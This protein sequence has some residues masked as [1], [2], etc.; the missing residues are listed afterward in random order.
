MEPEDKT[1]PSPP[2]AQEGSEGM[3]RPAE[4]ASQFLSFLPEPVTSIALSILFGP[5]GAFSDDQ[6]ESHIKTLRNCLKD[7][8]PSQ[9]L[10]RFFLSEIVHL[11][12]TS[13]LTQKVVDPVIVGL[14]LLCAG[15]AWS[16]EQVQ[17]ARILA[18]EMSFSWARRMAESQQE[19]TKVALAIEATMGV[20][21][22]VALAATGAASLV[23][24]HFA[25]LGGDALM[26]G[27]LDDEELAQ[28]LHFQSELVYS[29]VNQICVCHA[30]AAQ[31]TLAEDASSPDSILRSLEEM[32]R[33]RR[34]QLDRLLAALVNHPKGTIAFHQ[35][36][37]NKNRLTENSSFPLLTSS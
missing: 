10:W 13:R 2:W 1:A 30:R 3:D 25:M 15:E 7:G 32:K 4:L 20:E 31:A 8:D 19:D 9:V 21:A 29:S 23:E 27:P 37:S 28:Y 11:P 33:H 22:H 6:L 18:H 14:R 16:Y 36:V 35:A 34:L 24:G 26:G 17:E 5:P 12:K